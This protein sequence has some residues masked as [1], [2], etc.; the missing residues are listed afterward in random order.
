M[1]D[2]LGPYAL[3]WYRYDSTIVTKQPCEVV[4]HYGGQ[5]GFRAFYF[6]YKDYDLTVV[7]LA[8]MEMDMYLPATIEKILFNKEYSLPKIPVTKILYQS[9]EKDGFEKTAESIPEILG[10]GN[11]KIG[12]SNTLNDAGYSLLNEGNPEMAIHFFRLNAELFPDDAN[13]FDSLGEA[14]M[15]AGNNNLAIENYKKSLKLDPENANA[16]EMLNRLNSK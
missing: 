11:Y 3:L 16:K 7:I 4:G 8:N 1:K 6:Y 13:V 5:P 14:Y 9:F 10:T 12:N 2:A 15:K